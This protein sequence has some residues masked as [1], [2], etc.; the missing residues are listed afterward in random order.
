[1]EWRRMRDVWGLVVMA[2]LT[3]S[4]LAG[5]GGFLPEGDY[6]CTSTTDGGGALPSD[7]FTDGQMGSLWWLDAEDFANCWL[8]EAHQRLELRS[9]SGS[10][11]ASARYVS[12]NWELDA[13][14]NFSLRVDFH[15]GLKGSNATWL[16]VALVPN[17]SRRD[18]QYIKFGVGNSDGYSYFWY[19]TMD[20]GG[21]RSQFTSRDQD[22]GTL[23]LSYNA[24]KD[25]LYLAYKGYGASNAWTTIRGFVQGAWASSGLAVMLEGGSNRTQVTSG[26][27]HFDNFVVEAG[28]E[29]ASRFSDVYRF[30]SPITDAHFYTISKTER[31]KLIK[32]FSDVW[33]FEGVAFE[34]ATTPFVSGLAPVYRFWSDVT[35]SHLYTVSD[36]ERDKLVREYRDVWTF[37][38]IAFYAYPDGRQPYGTKP[39]YRFWSDVKTAHFYTISES[40]KNKFLKQ[41]CDVYTFEGIAFYAYE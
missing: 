5:S 7:Y 12:N 14:R 8:S 11:W 1:M 26:Q 13:K 20:D 15:Q 17:I 2:C 21:T 31:D 10:Q 24:G 37:E 41:Y 23:Y 27:A 39:V 33:T 40:E 28:D 9:T 29:T 19:E 4:A 30:W 38:G 16:A 32:D 22:N 35:Q 18:S 34:A 36:T 6:L 25:E 3:G